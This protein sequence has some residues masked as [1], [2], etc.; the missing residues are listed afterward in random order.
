ML[1]VTDTT[2]VIEMF[3]AEAMMWAWSEASV[4]ASRRAVCLAVWNSLSEAVKVTPLIWL[5]PLDAAVSM[6]CP[7]WGPS[8]ADVE[9]SMVT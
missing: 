1:V 3:S 6:T 9:V 7:A 8:C 2:P 4:A 5:A